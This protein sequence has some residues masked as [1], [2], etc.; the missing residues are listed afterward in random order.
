MTGVILIR[1]A[2]MSRFH[3]SENAPEKRLAIEN[4]SSTGR[5]LLPRNGTHAVR[6]DAEAWNARVE[7][8]KRARIPL[9]WDVIL[10]FPG[11]A[12]PIRCKTYDLSIDGFYC[13]V[14][15]T[16]TPGEQI[17]CD[18]LVPSY[19]SPRA[20]AL[21]CNAQVIRVEKLEDERYGLACRIDEYRV[22]RT[23]SVT[24]PVE[25]EVSAVCAR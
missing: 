20:L 17:E 23:H 15:Q 7:R 4:M 12:Q 2:A 16:L 24:A 14:G 21:Q 22:I 10:A 19:G 11:M 13:V 3:G 8:R 18:L 9:Q 6:S 25:A 1:E 5:E